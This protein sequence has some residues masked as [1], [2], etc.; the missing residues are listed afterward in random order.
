[1]SAMGGLRTFRGIRPNDIVR[2]FNARGATLAGA[3]LSDQVR[4]GVIQIATGAWFDPVTWGEIGSLDKDGNPNV[5][6]Q[7]R[8][9]SKLAQ[10]PVAQSTLVEVEKFMGAPPPLTAFEPP[11][12]S[13]R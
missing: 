10:G 4:P 11:L 7:D 9:T 8:G 6:T 1:M 12:Q 5:L 13:D 2:V 3:V